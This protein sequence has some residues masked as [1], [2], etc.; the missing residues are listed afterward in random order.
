MR[1]RWEQNPKPFQLDAVIAALDGKHV[2]VTAPT[3]AGKTRIWEV[4]APFSKNRMTLV[5]KPLLALGK[6]MV[7]RHDL[8]YKGFLN[9]RSGTTST[10][11]K[12]PL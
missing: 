8:S 4:L 5:I 3:G 11:P 2:K 9:P 7:G 10:T 12:S 6:D 1:T